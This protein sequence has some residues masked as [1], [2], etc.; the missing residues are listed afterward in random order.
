V[1]F[2][3]FILILHFFAQPPIQLTVAWRCTKAI[4]GSSKPNT[5]CC[6][7]GEGSSCFVAVFREVDSVDET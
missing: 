5:Y 6:I 4:A 2:I 7:I 1:D 3:L